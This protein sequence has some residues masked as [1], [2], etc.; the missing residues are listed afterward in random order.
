MDAGAPSF[1]AHRVSEGP[2]SESECSQ[3]RKRQREGG[4]VLGC[5]RH[6]EVLCSVADIRPS[7]LFKEHPPVWMTGSWPSRKHRQGLCPPLAGLFLED[8][9][10]PSRKSTSE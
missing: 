3:W 1:S 8:Q 7:S 5:G 9:E 2:R 4:F 10:V 6:K